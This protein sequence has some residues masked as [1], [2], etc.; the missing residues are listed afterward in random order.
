MERATTKHKIFLTSDDIL[1]EIPK[2]R[3]GKS[4]PEFKGENMKN[5]FTLYNDFVAKILGKHGIY[6]S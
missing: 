4:R 6:K 3:T 1:R 5:M 2:K